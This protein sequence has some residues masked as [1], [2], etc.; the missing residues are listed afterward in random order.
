[1]LGEDRS[2]AELA[3]LCHAALSSIETGPVDGLFCH[4]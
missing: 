2:L 3:R 1:M 4:Y